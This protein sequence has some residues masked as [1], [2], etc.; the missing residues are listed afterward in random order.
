VSTI[1]IAAL[2][3]RHEDRRMWHQLRRDGEVFSAFFVCLFG[4]FICFTQ[5]RGI[6]RVGIPDQNQAPYRNA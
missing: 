6:T 4:E 5:K 3:L 1:L 2:L